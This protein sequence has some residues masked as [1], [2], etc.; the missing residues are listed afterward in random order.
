MPK[1]D[2]FLDY[3]ENYFSQGQKRASRKERSL[4]R[5]KDRSKY[6]KS[7]Q[8]KLKKQLQSEEP[9]LGANFLRGRVLSIN[10]EMITVLSNHET[11]ICTLKGVL[12]KE[13]TR[14]KNLIAVGD[15][16]HFEKKSIDSGAI[17]HIEK[18]SSFLARADNLSRRKKQLLAV[19]IDQVFIV[20]SV[21]T[22]P[23]KPL[24]IDRY[25]IAAK[26]GNMHPII[27]I[28][29][30]DLLDDPPP[31]IQPS[32]VE[33]EKRLLADFEKAYA[34]LDIPILKLSVSTGHN[35]EKL[36]ALMQNKASVFSGQSGVGKSSLIN[37][38][39]GIDLA[40]GDVVQKTRK[41]SHTT[42]MAE[43]LP[44]EGDGFCIDTPGI[45]SFGVWD[46]T[47]EEISHFFSDFHPFES[48]C[49]FPNCTHLHEPD[50]A[51]KAALEEEKIHPL[52]YA[53]YST[54]MSEEPPKDWE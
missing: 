23:F 54:L 14:Q 5:S 16:V 38:V 8:D 25:I 11:F 50:C 32:E 2:D 27:L 49:K 47:P 12:K 35:L 36:K 1:F 52:R 22:P 42:T 53:S 15:W 20:M 46:I 30:V 34:D 26:K 29:K 48:Q 40:I 43:L 19:N 18:R 39:L 41:G 13:R 7:D 31:H 6:K 17:S 37:D 51:I 21:C 10:S 3:E 4:S 28:N 44:I 9:P 24:L 33:E 45:K